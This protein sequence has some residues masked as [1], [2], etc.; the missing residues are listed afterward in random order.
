MT[1]AS[2]LYRPS[3]RRAAA[4]RGRSSSACDWPCG[5]LMA[6]MAGALAGGI[7]RLEAALRAEAGRD[8]VA[9]PV[10]AGGR[11]VSPALLDP[12]PCHLAPRGRAR[13]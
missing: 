4:G 8:A 3:F 10:R 2:S 1:H 7:A 11:R 9:L 12:L 13:S 5:A 6:A